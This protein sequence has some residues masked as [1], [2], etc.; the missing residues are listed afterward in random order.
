MLTRAPGFPWAVGPLAV[1]VAVAVLHL[2]ALGLLP[3]RGTVCMVRILRKERNNPQNVK[4]KNA[5]A[6]ISGSL[7]LTDADSRSQALNPGSAPHRG[8]KALI[9]QG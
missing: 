6:K 5:H 4:V 7:Q 3:T 2:K 8:N 1:T 9:R